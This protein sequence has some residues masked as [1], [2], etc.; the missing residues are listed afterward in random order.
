[1]N[2]FN[3]HKPKWT[4]VKNIDT[5]IDVLIEYIYQNEPKAK[6]GGLNS[7]F[8]SLVPTIISTA[9]PRFMGCEKVFM[10]FSLATTGNK[11]S[12]CEYHARELERK[13]E[14]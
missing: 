10:N 14:R 13:R 8:L 5:E 11:A 2:I 3:V 4:K 9:N 12:S 7:S 6:V 1:M